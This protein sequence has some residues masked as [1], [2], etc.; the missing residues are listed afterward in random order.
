MSKYNVELA[1][2]K[3]KI[4][5]LSRKTLEAGCSEAE[6][7]AAM[8]IMGKLLEQ[9]NLT[10]EECDVRE[11]KCITVEIPFPSF[12]RSPID[13]AVV[14]LAQLF[15]GRIWFKK[16]YVGYR[17]RIT[18]R[19]YPAVVP[20]PS[21][22]CFFIQEHDKE[23]LEYLFAVMW[24]ALE[25]GVQ[26]YKQTD[27]YLSRPSKAKAIR[28]FK[29]G[30][31]VRLAERLQYM[32]EDADRAYAGIKGS[33]ALIVLKG[34]LIEEEWQKQ[35]GLKLSKNYYRRKG[36]SDVDAYYDGHSAADKIN[37]N[38]PLPEGDKIRG[39]IGA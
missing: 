17:S 7:L 30:M 3:A 21:Q 23:A 36:I 25:N 8:T 33:N 29:I 6:S 12:R 5:A 19:F 27:V 34:Q 10:M 18:G 32:K 37:L 11:S 9:Y 14:R 39:Y 4:M 35:L 38:R 13:G 2:V 22:Y 20:T 15:H 31:N 26:A 24:Y 28:S 16:G 1:K